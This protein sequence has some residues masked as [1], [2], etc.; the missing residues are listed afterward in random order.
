MVVVIF[1]VLFC[2]VR[3]FFSFVSLLF[4]G[5]LWFFCL[6]VGFYGGDVY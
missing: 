4:F 1:S 5:G 2:F 6:F 3:Y